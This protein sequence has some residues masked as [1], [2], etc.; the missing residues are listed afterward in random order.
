MKSAYIHIP[1]CKSF[2]YYC[3]FC[4]L[5]SDETRQAQYL[6]LLEE[7]IKKNYQGEVL[8]TIYIGG[9]T[10]NVLT[11]EQLRKLLALLDYFNL[12][13]DCEITMEI[14]CESIDRAKLQLLYQ[15]VN[16]LSFG[17]QSFQDHLL[18]KLGRQHKG[19]LAQEKICLAQTIG[20][21]NISVDLI[22]GVAGM[23]LDDLQKDIALLKKLNVC[24]VSCYAL[25]LQ[26]EVEKSRLVV[27]EQTEITMY[28]YLRDNL[29]GY[30]QYEVGNFA[31]PGWEARHNLTYWRNEEYYG[32]GLG[33]VGYVAGKRYQNATNWQDYLLGN[34]NYEEVSWQAQIENEFIL[35][36]RLIS[37]INE[38]AFT[39]KYGYYFSDFPI[40]AHLIATG[41][42]Q[43]VNGNLLLDERNIY[44]MNDIL[45]ELLEG[46][47]SD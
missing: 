2:C 14:N 8:S 20:F 13:S 40:I 46:L 41:K 7:E 26:D 29:T 15:K 35:G 39:K 23:A 32:F 38:Q 5:L 12:S 45:V 16:R 18:Q 44:I 36:L 9:G 19:A 24:H 31:K 27:D 33:A 4:K 25:T 42:L 28:E 30:Q 17:V 6:L 3:D 21:R 1:F 47:W 10:P 11:I 43:L 37:G 34:G 22:Y